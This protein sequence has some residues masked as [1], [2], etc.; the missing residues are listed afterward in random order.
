MKKFFLLVMTAAAVLFA[1]SCSKEQLSTLTPVGEQVT[2]TLTADLGAIGSRAIADGLKVNEVAWAIYLEGEDTPL[3][4]MQGVIPISQKQGTLEVRLVT[5]RSYDIA[6]FAYS[7]ENPTTSQALTI[8][9]AQTAPSYYSVD[10]NNKMVSVLYPDGAI[11]NDTDKRDC[12]WHVE[13]GLKVTAPVNKTFTLTRPLAQLNFGSSE[14]DTVAAENAGLVVTKSKIVA[15]TYTKFNLFTG[16]CLDSQ[17]V[18]YTFAAN[19]VPNQALTVQ[20][21]DYTYLGTTYL[22]VNEQM[23]QDVSLTVYDQAGEE[24]NTLNYSYA[25]FQRNYRT[26]ILGYLLTDPAK[27]T[28]VVDESFL[29]PDYNIVHWNGETK[30]ITPDANGVYNVTEAAELAWIADQVNSGSNDFSGKSVVIPASVDAIDLNS[31]NNQ[32]W[33]PIGTSGKP[34]KGSFDG[35]GVVIRNVL[36]KTTECAGLFGNVVGS[37]ANVNLKDVTIEAGHYAGAVAGYAYADITGCTVNGLTIEVTPYSTTRAAYD[38]GDKAGGIVGYVGEKSGTAGYAINNN[39]VTKATIT[40]YRDLGGIAGAA[41]LAEFKGNAIKDSSLTVDQEVNNYGTKDA[42]LNELVGRLLSGTV[43]KDEN[44][45]ENVTLTWN[46]YSLRPCIEN[47]IAAGAKSGVTAKGYVLATSADSFLLA[48]QTGWIMVYRPKNY[49][50]TM[51]AVG[52]VVSV[53]GTTSL[54]PSAKPNMLQF[55]QNTVVTVLDEPKVEVTHPTSEVWTVE[56]IEAYATAPI[57]TFGT[58]KGKLN[59]NTNNNTTYYN[60]EIEGTQKQGS[61][62]APKAEIKNLISNNGLN[63]KTIQVSGYLTYL[64]S[65]KYLN[66]MIT[67]FVDCKQA[68]EW[69]VVGDM[70]SWGETPDITMYTYG[71]GVMFARGVEIAEGQGFKIRANNEWNNEK[72]YGTAD[73]KVYINMAQP[74]YSDGGSGNIIPTEGGKFDIYFDLNKKLVYVMESGEAMEDALEYEKFEEPIHHNDTWRIVG[75]F[76][77]WNPNDDNYLMTLSKDNKWATITI[78]FAEQTQLKFVANGNWDKNF[79]NGVTVE[80]DK[81]YAGYQGGGDITVPAGNYK[82]SLSMCDGRFKFENG[83][84]EVTKSLSFANKAQ[85][86]TFNSNKQVWEQ[87][88]IVLTNDKD[89]STSSVADYANPARFYKSSKITI[90]AGGQITKI[91]FDCNSSSYATSLQKSLGSALGTVSVSGD[92]V[93]LVPTATSIVFNLTD[94]QVRMDSISVTWLE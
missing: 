48:D 28:I 86:T 1:S 92:K 63:G 82:I 5:G 75:S 69:G 65:S 93:T 45:V 83:V 29:E 81:E 88:G 13:K 87:N 12:F 22:L 77:N 4:D 43:N 79:G 70:T 91:V 66:M 40:A 10:W 53:N 16:E 20:D 84:T 61:I 62:L 36:I 94:A 60:I 7:T 32:I 47:V 85:R 64:N 57:R 6:L 56:Q 15:S 30:A 89:K 54:Y 24:I 51:P 17:V 25:P 42:N 39:T 59:V 21:V 46:P 18:E 38:N 58:L 41:Y 73:P 9:G 8:N 35:N 74:V 90:T 27:F 68:T 50:T 11:A 78:S 80:L 23:T 3:S 14:E 37:I 26:N 44:T 34:F 49:S 67:D 31:T 72:N 55:A 52:D 19:A 2:V 76:N 33:T 71:D